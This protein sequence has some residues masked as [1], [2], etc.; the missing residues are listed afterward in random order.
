MSVKTGARAGEEKLENIRY[1]RYASEYATL[2]NISR[3]AARS[4]KSRGKENFNC[5]IGI[6]L[7][8]LGMYYDRF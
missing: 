6:R 3:F 8:S 7:D 2:K 1:A 5:T 4:V